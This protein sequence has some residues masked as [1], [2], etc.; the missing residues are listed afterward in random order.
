MNALLVGL[1]RDELSLANEAQRNCV[2]NMHMVASCL[3]LDGERKSAIDI[4]RDV[5]EMTARNE[6][7]RQLR[8]DDM[9]VSLSIIILILKSFLSSYIFHY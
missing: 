2:S 6:K 3:A 9:Q 7:T 1:R 4:Y 8:F 5:L